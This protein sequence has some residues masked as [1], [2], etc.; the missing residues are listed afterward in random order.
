MCWKIITEQEVIVQMYYS[1]K[2]SSNVE[3]IVVKIMLCKQLT[4]MYGLNFL[5]FVFS[6]SVFLSW[7][8]DVTYFNNYW[9][10]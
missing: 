4:L 7:M 8:D 2:S 5:P 6:L 3:Y 1:H 10:Q 9:I